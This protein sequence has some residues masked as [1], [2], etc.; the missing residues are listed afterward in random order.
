MSDGNLTTEA[1]VAAVANKVTYAGGTSA[2]IGGLTAN[3][4][5][6]IGGLLIALIGLAI[7]WYY[8]R[9]D[10]RRNAE[11]HTARMAVLRAGRDDGE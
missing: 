11:E 6:A 3:E 4:W 8:K 2:V 9:K 5:A 10:D 1:A 7:Q